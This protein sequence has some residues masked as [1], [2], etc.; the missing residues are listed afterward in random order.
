MR[1]VYMIL[2][3]K[4]NSEVDFASIKDGKAAIVGVKD[5]DDAIKTAK[6]LLKMGYDAFELCGGFKKEGADQLVKAL[7]YQVPIGYAIHH[8]DAEEAYRLAR[9]KEKK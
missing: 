4:Y 1:F 8:P 7:D 2:S 5:I 9:E 3:S 6:R